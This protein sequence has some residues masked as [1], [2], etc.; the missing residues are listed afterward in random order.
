MNTDGTDGGVDDDLLA[1]AGDGTSNPPMDPPDDYLAQYGSGER[2]KVRVQR[3]ESGPELFVGFFDSELEQPCSFVRLSDEEL[4]C[5]PEL[6]MGLTLLG[7]ADDECTTPV[8]EAS[9]EC[10]LEGLELFR[11]SSRGECRDEV[12]VHRLVAAQTSVT[13]HQG[14][15]G[16]DCEVGMVVDASPQLFVAEEVADPSLFVSGVQYDL[17]SAGEM[18]IRLTESDDGAFGPVSLVDVSLGIVCDSGF[19]EEPQACSPTRRAW[20]DA[21]LF[22][23]DM[24]TEAEEYAYSPVPSSCG[25]IDLI[26][27]PMGGAYY[28]PGPDVVEDLWYEQGDTCAPASEAPWLDNVIELGDEVDASE[29]SEVSGSRVGDSRLQMSV[30]SEGDTSLF[31]ARIYYDS[32]FEADCR[33]RSMGDELLCVPGDYGFTLRN[34]D[35]GLM[36]YA[37]S[38][39]SDELVYCNTGSCEQELY[40]DGSGDWVCSDEPPISDLRRLVELYTDD[41]YAFEGDSCTGPVA[42][43]HVWTWESVEAGELEAVELVVLD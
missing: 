32:D 1:D 37:D 13:L 2:I 10:G 14:S 17:P 12:E 11:R 8:Y 9:A 7:Y 24:C 35:P 28:E 23:D 16:A 19:S 36:Q 34:Y 41:V 18:T 6:P 27:S 21:T 39:C 43:Y 5:V 4:H 42:P 3:S 26:I 31:A 30:L 15:A 25:N 29:L 20:A 22:T 38:E 33:P 40:F